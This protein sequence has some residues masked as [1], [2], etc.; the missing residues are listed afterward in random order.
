MLRPAI[1]VLLLL[2][3]PTG[4]AAQLHP[5]R[6]PASAG[7]NPRAIE[8]FE[9]DWLLMD[10]A[11][12]LYDTDKDVR[13]SAQEAHTAAG[14]FKLLADGNSDGRV[15]PTEFR[16]ARAVHLARPRGAPPTRTS[17]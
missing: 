5:P 16:A 14:Q 2:A 15:T 3:P 13:L 17:V 7:V 11:L 6:P 4:A 8:L 1:A 12:R 9:R 10:W